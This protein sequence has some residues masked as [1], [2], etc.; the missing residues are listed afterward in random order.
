MQYCPLAAAASL[1][2][3][4]AAAS[5]PACG[6]CATASSLSASPMPAVAS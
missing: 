3:P 2:S 1:E 4:V 6:V 5:S